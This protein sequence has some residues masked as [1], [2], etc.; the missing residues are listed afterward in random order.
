M[1][2]IGPHLAE[3]IEAVAAAVA[4]AVLIWGITKV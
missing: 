2:D 4:F 3:A 1:I